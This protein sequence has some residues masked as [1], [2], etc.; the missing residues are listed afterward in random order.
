MNQKRF[1]SLFWAAILKNHCHIWNQHPRIRL[2]TKFREETKM[3]KLRT[4]NALFEYSLAIICKKYFHIWNQY[5]RIYLIAKFCEK[6]KMAKFL[7]KNALFRHFGARILKNYC[8]IWNQHARN[9]HNWVFNLYSEFWYRVRFF[10]TEFWYKVQS[11]SR[12]VLQ[13]TSLFC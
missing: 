2:I 5:P 6:M 11:G 8:H 12:S 10:Q 13:S 7:D 9:C 4:K 3:S 1:I